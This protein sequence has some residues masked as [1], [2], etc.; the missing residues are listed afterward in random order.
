MWGRRLPLLHT[1]RFEYIIW[2][3]IQHIHSENTT[4]LRSMFCILGYLMTLM[5]PDIQTDS[6]TSEGRGGQ[7]FLVIGALAS[8]K[9]A[10]PGSGGHYRNILGTHP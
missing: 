5:T 8:H 4:W 1:N 9:W 10:F 6:S 7:C 2:L 3:D